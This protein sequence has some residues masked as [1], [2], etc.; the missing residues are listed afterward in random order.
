MIPHGVEEEAIWFGV[1]AIPVIIGLVQLA[2]I[3]FNLSS[4][5][6][7]IVAVGL[8]IVGG[9]VSHATGVHDRSVLEA[10]FLG[11]LAGLTACGLYSATKTT[12]SNK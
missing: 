7:P 10:G 12:V 6:A 3:T 5:F 2:K 11:L 4:R 1:A 9:V 8:G